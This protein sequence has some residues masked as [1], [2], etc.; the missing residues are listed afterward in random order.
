MSQLN[1][2]TKKFLTKWKGPWLD[3]G[4]VRYTMCSG[5]CMI[6]GKGTFIAAK[7]LSARNMKAWIYLIYKNF[8]TKSLVVR[9]NFDMKWSNEEICPAEDY[10][11]CPVKPKS[12]SLSDF[13]ET[14]G[15][16][17][18]SKSTKEKRCSCK[19]QYSGNFCRSLIY[20]IENPKNSS[21]KFGHIFA[22]I[23]VVV[24]VVST[25]VIMVAVFR[26]HKKEKERISGNASSQGFIRTL[27]VSVLNASMLTSLSKL[28]IYLLN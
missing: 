17:C 8:N 15:I 26:H 19:S 20:R 11:Y 25:A 16:C 23:G 13:P 5:M 12:Y 1:V 14:N 27:W 9:Q 4:N 7:K 18:R 21:K 28:S 3:S 22:V 6:A 24:F 2:R 10:T